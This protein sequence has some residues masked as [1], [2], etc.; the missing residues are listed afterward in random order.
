MK[1][2]KKTQRDSISFRSVTEFFMFAL[3][4]CF[5]DDHRRV[6]PSFRRALNEAIF[7]EFKNKN[8]R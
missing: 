8:D 4:I 3:F 1:T 7:G 5:D 2:K 6:E